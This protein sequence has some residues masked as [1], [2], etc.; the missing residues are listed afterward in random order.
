M[1]VNN[2]DGSLLGADPDA[3]DVVGSLAECLQVFV[4]DVS[5]LNGG[6]CVEFCRVGD[7]KENVL[8]DVGAEGSLELEGLALETQSSVD[9]LRL[10]ACKPTLKRTS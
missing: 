7:L 8:H 4:D 10:Q 3:L 9:L 6:L 5:S 1:L 2:T